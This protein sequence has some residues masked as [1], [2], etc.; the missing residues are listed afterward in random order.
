MI[1]GI[2]QREKYSQ[3][4]NGPRFLPSSCCEEPWESEAMEPRIVS[5]GATERVLDNYNSINL[6]HLISSDHVTTH[7]PLYRMAKH[8]RS[9]MLEYLF[10]V[11]IAARI[12]KG[13]LQFTGFLQGKKDEQ[14]VLWH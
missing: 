10:M 11:D 4:M 7:D 5:R 6:V 1:N 9:A 8:C 13:N 2:I 14:N 12:K 3:W